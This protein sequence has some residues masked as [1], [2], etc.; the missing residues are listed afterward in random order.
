MTLNACIVNYM[1]EQAGPPSKQIQA[2]KQVQEFLKDGDD[3]IVIGVFSGEQDVAYRIFQ[4]ACNNLRE[5]YAFHHTFSN[6]I[7]KFLKALPGQMVV[8][9]PE[10]FQSKYEPKMCVFD[11]K[12]ST[13]ESDVK[14]F[15]TTHALPLVGHRK[16]AND[17]KRYSK[18]PLVLVYYGVD[19]SFDYRVGKL[20]FFF[21]CLLLKHLFPRNIVPGPFITSSLFC[22]WRVFKTELPAPTQPC[23]P[24]MASGPSARPS[25]PP[26]SRASF[27]AL[28]P[29]HAG[30]PRAIPKRVSCVDVSSGEGGGEI[31]DSCSREVSKALYAFGADPERAAKF[32]AP[33]QDASFQGLLEKVAN[34][35]AFEISFSPED[36]SRFMQVLR[37][38]VSPPGSLARHHPFQVGRSLSSPFLGGAYE[39]EDRLTLPCL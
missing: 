35:L 10:K 6:K 18:Y 39:Q 9:Q 26:T 34:V 13:T 2:V 36:Q 7:A 28:E 25:R 14:E 11:I 29:A 24:A 1:I 8:M 23:A 19:F 21:F 30:P 15:V 17:A 4:D 37:G 16:Q 38:R 12:D 33:T 20:A 3:V 5:D 27:E 31:E 32:N 22:I